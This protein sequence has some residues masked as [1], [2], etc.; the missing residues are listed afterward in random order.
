LVDRYLVKSSLQNKIIPK[1][2]TIDQLHDSLQSTLIRI[3]NIEFSAADTGKAYA[4]AVNKLSVNNTLK[5]C[6]SGTV[7]L[8]TSGYANFASLK[9]PRGNGSITAVYSVFITEKQLMIR[10]TSDIQMSG[11]RCTGTGAK[12]LFS[13]DFEN[14]VPNSV[15]SINS[16]KNL[17]ETG[18]RNFL[19]KLAANNHY[20]E[21]SAFATGQ[22]SVISWLILPVVNLNNSANEVFSFQTKDGFDNGGVL[23]VYLSTNY[24][25]AGTPWKANTVNE[26]TL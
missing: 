21:I 3:S 2:I 18:G 12:V 6:G 9:T 17:P 5:A 7:Y 22:A 1:E 25:G 14:T 26:R 13:E 8:R 4:D 15:V 10:D 23:Q 11:L 24:D 19:S 20:A 16:W